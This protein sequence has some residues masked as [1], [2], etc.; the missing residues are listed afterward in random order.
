MLKKCKKRTIRI[1][2]LTG[3]MIAALTCMGVFFAVSAAEDN[4]TLQ[5]NVESE[6]TMIKPGMPYD[7]SFRSE[8][9]DLEKQI[10]DVLYD[11]L[12]IQ[13]SFED[14]ENTV[15]SDELILQDADETSDSPKLRSSVGSAW[16]AFNYDYPEV[17][18]TTGPQ[19][20]SIINDNTVERS[21]FTFRKEY[22]PNSFS[23]LGL[24]LD[25]INQAVDLIK[26]E[27][28]SDSRYD[29]VKAIH[30]YI[31]QNAE[32][33]YDALTLTYP[34]EANTLAPLFGGGS[35]GKMFV[36]EGYARAFKVLCN[37]LNVPAVFVDGQTITGLHAWNYVQME[38]NEWY[39]MDVTWDDDNS[40]PYSYFLVGKNTFP[41]NDPNT[42]IFSHK[43]NGDF[44]SSESGNFGYPKLSDYEYVPSDA[45]EFWGESTEYGRTFS[46]I[47]QIVLKYKGQLPTNA[48]VDI[49]VNNGNYGTYP[50][51]ENG[52]VTVDIDT[53]ELNQWTDLEVRA[54]CNGFP[55]RRV[56]KLNNT[57]LEFLNWESENPLFSGVFEIKCKGYSTSD[58]TKKSLMIFLDSAY[59]NKIYFNSDGIV[60]YPLDTTV[61]T[62]GTHKLNFVLLNSKE[63]QNDSIRK[64]FRVY[65][66]ESGEPFIFWQDSARQGRVVGEYAGFTVKYNGEIN[67]NCL[68]N[69]YIDNQAVQTY[70]PNKENILDAFDSDG[71]CTFYIDVRDKAVGEHTVRFDLTDS[72]GNTV[73]LSNTITVTDGY[74]TIANW[75]M[76]NPIFFKEVPVDFK[77]LSDD[78]GDQF[79]F[80]YSFGEFFSTWKTCQ[81]QD[82]YI[83]KVSA[84]TNEFENEENVVTGILK[85]ADGVIV[86]KSYPYRINDNFGFYG[87]CTANNGLVSTI[88]ELPVKYKGQI[89]DKC[90]ISVKVDEQPA[91]FWYFGSDSI[92]SAFDKNGICKLMIDTGTQT[93]GRHIVKAEL[94][95]DNGNIQIAERTIDVTNGYFDFCNWTEEVEVQPEVSTEF[96]FMNI[97][98]EPIGTCKLLAKFDCTIPIKVS[99][100][101]TEDNIF[102]ATIDISDYEREYH[103]VKAVFTTPSGVTIEKIRRFRT[104]DAVEHEPQVSL[105]KFSLNM[106]VGENVTLHAEV[107]YTSQAVAWT[108]SNTD[109]ATVSNGTVTAVGVGTATITAQA[110]SKSA[111]CTVTVSEPTP[112]SYDV[113]PNINGGAS[114]LYE[115]WGLRYYA[116]FNG[117]DIDKI[118]DRGIAILKETYYTSGMTPEQF[119][120]NQNANIFLSS[121]NELAFEN[122]TSSNPNG[123]YFATLTN[124][125]YS[126][127]IGAKYYVVPFA[128]M[129]NGQTIYGTIKS[130][131]MENILKA[132]LN[133]PTITKEEKAICTCILEL[134][135]SVAAHYQAAGVPGASVDMNIPRGSSQS[136]ATVKTPA[137]TGI[138]PNVVG[139][140][141]RLIE[142]WGLRY[143]STYPESADIAQKGMVILSEKY[144]QSSYSS[145]PD[146]M[147]LNANA[148]VFRDSDGTLIKQSETNRYFGTVTEGISSKDIADVYYVV[149]FVVLN[150]GSYVYGTVKSNS[151]MKI[152][153][154]NLNSSSVPAS[155]RAV[156]QDIVDLYNAVKA[157]YAAQ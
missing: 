43:P 151:M 34:C 141:S 17:Y 4:A 128:V 1:V 53:T 125:I 45:V 76:Y 140:A 41:Q 103:F 83:A 20:N 137:E 44:Y 32:Y 40:A 157:Y 69:A 95:D 52:F 24:I 85:T 111:T 49:Y 65:N 148:Y 81:S 16:R 78:L 113:T 91:Q 84:E 99:I 155:E 13:K 28:E 29:T 23:E 47:A 6:K 9:T 122:A 35:R 68:F 93:D 143:F 87:K 107:T 147:R 67:Q 115:P 102:I 136:A 152:M 109:V 127:D 61:L 142:P 156:S 146:N 114:K 121:K 70:T 30:D 79:E 73:S 71:F 48:T 132:N 36:C 90:S 144:Y 101:T 63:A 14:F 10:Y 31:C 66:S 19:L 39:G 119:C 116:V 112:V 104:V 131:S 7:G 22:Y 18:L 59:Q 98:G 38:D 118:S 27:R 100:S 5:N 105:D 92:T 26:L 60:N 134:K 89:T 62:N 120:T 133:L 8:L 135:K 55:V 3:L 25:G 153:N 42:F 154:A 130:N 117:A 96:R 12:I 82:E 106:K 97:S 74:F 123:R 129:N 75:T 150:D 58:V 64:T 110:G 80:S 72:Q 139:G 86:E 51:D 21:W 145:S 149:P 11:R 126:Y 124:G 138:T 56:Y 2:L 50:V 57:L 33:D 46:G 94:I 15:I 37:R 108:S 88:V 54:E 77:R